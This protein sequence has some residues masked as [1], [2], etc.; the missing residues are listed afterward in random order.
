MPSSEPPPPETSIS[1]RRTRAQSHRR[2]GVDREDGYDDDRADPL[3]REHRSAWAA[4]RLPATPRHGRN[5]SRVECLAIEPSPSWGQ[6]T[7][8]RATS[9]QGTVL[10]RRG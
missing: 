2:R 5:P 6:I 4:P 10:R 7:C 8:N 9:H 1:S 3:N